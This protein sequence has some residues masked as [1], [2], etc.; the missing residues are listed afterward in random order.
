MKTNRKKGYAL[1]TVMGI[2]AVL[3]ITFSMLLRIGQQ[4]A[5]TGRL[6]K[7]R[8]KATSYAEAGIE[9]AYALLR[10]DFDLRNTPSAFLLDPSQTNQT[11]LTS[12]Y[13][14]G[15]FT[16]SFTN[17]NDQYVVINSVGTCGRASVEVE[18][19]V[20]DTNFNGGEAWEK[21]I[22]GGGT[23]KIGGGGL[24]G[25]NKTFHCNGDIALNGG[26]TIDSDV[27]SGGT[28]SGSNPVSG[29]L[30]PNAPAISPPTLEPRYPSFSD[31]YNMADDSGQVY[32]GKKQLRSNLVIPGGVMFVDGDVFIK[33]NITGTIIATGNI[34]FTKGGVTA[35]GA[36]IAVATPNGDIDYGTTGSS[37][38]LF[39]SQTG[40]FSQTASAGTITG[41]IIVGGDVEKTG[42]STIIFQSSGS[43]ETA[44]NPVIAGWQK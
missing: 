6:L 23:G 8:V 19:M 37:E 41:Q 25:T 27:T 18:T 36:G 14:D 12:A 44:A 20:E 33:A 39:Y 13:D 2:M 34:I 42:G 5:F 1:V 4:G 22:F 38:G 7:D 29:S 24:V 40:D 21:A 10:D 26:A 3:A 30:T 15:A 31:F 16:I 32:T 11:A 43:T 17:M 9:F 28:I 35:T